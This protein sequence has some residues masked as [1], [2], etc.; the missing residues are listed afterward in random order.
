MAKISIENIE[1]ISLN[2]IPH[3]RS[4]D[5]VEGFVLDKRVR[6]M[7]EKKQYDLQPKS[8]KEAEERGI[9]HFN[10]LVSSATNIHVYPANGKNF[11][12]LDLAPTR[13]LIGQAMRDCVAE[14]SYSQ[15]EILKMSPDMTGVSLIVPIKIDGKY[16]LLS[17]I[18]GKALGSGQVHTGLV[19][20]N[21][22]AKYLNEPN[23]LV[24]TLKH[25]CSEELGLD[26]SYMNSTSFIFLVDERETGQ[27]NFASVARNP[28][29]D[30]ILGSYEAMTINKLRQ[31]ESLE[32]MALTRLP[33]AGIAL[34]PLK[35]GSSGVKDIKCYKPSRDGLIESLEDRNVRPY[36]AATIDYLSKKENVRFLLDKAGF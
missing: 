17:Q 36:T 35:D 23:P 9:K 20:G 24:A 25:E 26:L 33:I 3:E 21:V 10:G 29:V 30:K 11:V 16:F 34:M 32:V 8:K 4:F 14:S 22:D 6:E 31:D 5:S 2:V 13:Y 1:D 27:I 28:D 12:T 19:A 18:K 15:E 7:Y